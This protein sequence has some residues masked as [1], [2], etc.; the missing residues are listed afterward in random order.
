VFRA[1]R[2]IEKL[3]REYQG[4]IL[5]AFTHGTYISA[6]RT[7]LGDK[8]LLREDRMIAFRD[9]ILG[10]AVPHWLGTWPNPFILGIGGYV[11]AQ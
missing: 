8:T 2:L 9:N 3:N 11:E 5:I 7:V 1:K 10:P 4:R 6:L